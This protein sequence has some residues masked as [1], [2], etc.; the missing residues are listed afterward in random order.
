MYR[1]SILKIDGSNESK[2]F[3]TKELC[4]EWILKK[5]EICNIKKTVI[6]NKDN[7]QERYI[8]NWE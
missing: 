3:H 7:I 6:V 5:S 1:V 8:E 2:N 4:E